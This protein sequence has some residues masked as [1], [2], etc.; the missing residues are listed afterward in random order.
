MVECTFYFL[1]FLT[2]LRIF[3]MSCYLYF[4]L[5]GHKKMNKTICKPTSTEE[6]ADRSRKGEERSAV[7]Q[8]RAGSRR[9]RNYV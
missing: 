2:T 7:N 1:D 6:Q 8:G 3:H 9:Q 4:S 5:L